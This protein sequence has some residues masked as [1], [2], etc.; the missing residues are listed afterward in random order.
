MRRMNLFVLLALGLAGAASSPVMASGA[1]A[2]TKAEAV[3]TQDRAEIMDLYA[4]YAFYVDQRQAEAYAGLYTKDGELRFPSADSSDGRRTIKGT[5]QLEQAIRDWGKSG[6]TG[7]H[8]MMNPILVRSGDGHVHAL[9]TVMTGKIDPERAYAANFNGYGMSYDD[10]VKVDGRW[11]FQVRDSY[12]YNQEP[13]R[14]EFLPRLE[15]K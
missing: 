14:P 4:R 1:G 6:K 12:I 10:I 11:L 15:A 7:I 3:S 8:I 2:A 5:A 13:V 9:T